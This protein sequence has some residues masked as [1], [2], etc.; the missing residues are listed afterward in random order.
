VNKV[1]LLKRTVT[2][3]SK[4]TT[5]QVL[6]QL[7][8]YCQGKSWTQCGLTA[9]A[10]K[11]RARLVVA[12]QRVAHKMK[13]PLAAAKQPAEINYEMLS[14]LLEKQKSWHLQ[15]MQFNHAFSQRLSQHHQ[16]QQPAALRDASELERRDLATAAAKAVTESLY[17]EFKTACIEENEEEWRENA[18]ADREAEW[19]TTWIEEFTDN[20]NV[21]ALEEMQTDVQNDVEEEIVEVVQDI[22]YESMDS[23]SEWSWDEDATWQTN[24]KEA[25]A[26]LKT[27]PRHKKQRR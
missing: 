15:Q 27:R 4:P 11:K 16:S 22:L 2:S 14:P 24:W 20:I 7:K 3:S 18:I 8:A 9:L 12:A 10:V 5:K 17:K 6:Q 1:S 26:R 19:K 25:V 23:D 21:E 13:T